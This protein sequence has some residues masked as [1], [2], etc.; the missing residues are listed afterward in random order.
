MRFLEIIS[1]KTQ[2]QRKREAGV[3]HDQ[4]F[5]R[6]EVAK[7]FADWVKGHDFYKSVSKVIE[8]AAGNMDL[9]KN[10]PNIEM[11]DLDPKAPE[12]S[13]QDF[14]TS[15]HK[16]QPGF[17][18]VMNPPFGK[19]SDLAVKFFNK[20]ATYSDYI[21]MIVPRTFRREGIQGKLSGN[22]ELVDEYVLPKGSFYLPSE[23]P[24]K[25]YDVPA[26]AQIWHRTETERQKPQPAQVPKGIQFI[27]HPK[28]ANV[29]FRRKGRRAGEIITQNLE[30]TNPNSF[31]YLNV[32]SPTL[33]KLQSIDWS[34]YGHDVMGARSISQSDIVKAIS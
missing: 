18:T 5:T 11:Y 12:I 33:R 29:A 16:Y 25:R 20:A 8:P 9:A 15:Q 3:E 32:D 10:F 31:F 26:V 30:A 14:F 27:R 1:E 23:G 13:A 7:Q 22:F 34:E 19:A 28:Q 24:N 17:L 4:F 21:A 2:A 6:P